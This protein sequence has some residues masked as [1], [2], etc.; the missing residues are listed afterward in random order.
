LRNREGKTPLFLAANA[1][2]PEQVRL[3]REAGAHL[4]SDEMAAAKLAAKNSVKEEI[5]VQ[6]GID[7]V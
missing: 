3:L 5:W 7:A 4:H 1:G 6:A 2:L